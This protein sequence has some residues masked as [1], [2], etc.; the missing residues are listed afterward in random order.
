[1]NSENSRR[2]ACDRC[3]NHKLR[4]VRLSKRGS[5]SNKQGLALCERCQKAGVECINSLA[6]P[7]KTIRAASV[8]SSLQKSRRPSL[9]RLFPKSTSTC[10]FGIHRDYQSASGNRASDTSSSAILQWPLTNQ[11]GTKIHGQQLS[12]EPLP[13][14]NIAPILHQEL[15]TCHMFRTS[16]TNL[17]SLGALN[18]QALGTGKDP[19]S[20]PIKRISAE[21]FDFGMKPVPS[22]TNSHQSGTD[23]ADSLPALN[24]GQPPGQ[25]GEDTLD[26]RDDLGTQ[27]MDGKGDY[28]HRL[29]ELNSLLVR[30]FSRNSVT[31]LIEILSF[32]SCGS[33]SCPG[34][35]QEPENCPHPKNAIGRLLESS[36]AF[37]DILK[38]FKPAKPVSMTEDPEIL[39]A[40]FWDD[41]EFAQLTS[42]ITDEQSATPT[43]M[44][45]DSRISI[46]TSHN[47]YVTEKAKETTTSA[48]VS[49][50]A[51][52]GTVDMPTMLT[53]LTCY[54]W[55]LQ[56]YETI[57]SSIRN[58]LLP[59][60]FDHAA[61]GDAENKL[62]PPRQVPRATTAALA[63]S[64]ILPGLR[65]GGF[66]LDN[67]SGLQVEMLVRL[68]SAMLE[69][70]EEAL[71][72]DFMSGTQLQVQ[73]RMRVQ[74]AT[75]TR[76]ACSRAGSPRAGILDAAAASAMLDIMFKRKDQ[77][78]S[79]D[80]AERIGGVAML[81]HTME[82]IQEMVRGVH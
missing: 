3:R 60:D 34:C 19:I 57:F 64:L 25:T 46:T 17:L 58:C 5:P 77:L 76:P 73:P 32:S 15:K 59:G 48:G 47:P 22:Y 56:G 75:G 35:S 51:A 65:F 28:L 78:I 38:C 10:E 42:T 21:N 74:D 70:I 72:I 18:T 11:Q 66:D 20:K 9:H 49:H 4:C 41:A 1:M 50:A 82:N 81:R 33:P 36:Q 55:L 16:H 54:I 8:S 45:L 2:S 52:S 26:F 67:H 68:S 12:R 39:H 53:M 63:P 24:S 62:F 61:A 44:S 14:Q 79:G 80:R 31:N 29:C 40:D 37:L 43:P 6:H 30:E 7:R 23:L 27:T 13:A 69:R 71:G